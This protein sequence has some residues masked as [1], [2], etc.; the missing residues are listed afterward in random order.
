MCDPE[1]RCYDLIRGLLEI[2]V[3]PWIS[4]PSKQINAFQY[5]CVQVLQKKRKYSIMLRLLIF[6]KSIIQLSSA[7][8]ELLN[9]ISIGNIPMRMLVCLI[10]G[11]YGTGA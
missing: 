8:Y 3:C 1:R 2:K 10:G 11:Y 4:D 6:K 9:G 5:A 7:I